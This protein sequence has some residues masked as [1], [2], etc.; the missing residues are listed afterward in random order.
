MR[1]DILAIATLLPL[2]ASTS[3]GALQTKP[4][5]S[6]DATD[7]LTVV[8]CIQREADYRTEIKEG[9]GGIAGTGLG[10]SHE[11]VLRS[12]RTVSAETLKP[13]ATTG[14]NFEA[15][16]RLGGKLEGEFDK[17]VGHQVAI[18]GYVKVEDT[19]GTKKVGDLPDMV[20]VGWRSIADHCAPAR[21]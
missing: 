15:I 6:R 11:F 10:E 12:A 20:V 18:S 13:L 21:K 4:Q 17:A 8:G 14:S 3:A 5:P 9:K 7:V 16:Y 2:L 19:K 1:S